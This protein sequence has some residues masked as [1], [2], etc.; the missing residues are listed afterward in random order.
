MYKN[1]KTC[2]KIDGKQSEEFEVKVEVHQS[3][4]LSPLLFAMVMDKIA[5]DV[6]EGCVKELVYADDMKL[7][8]NNRKKKLNMHNGKY[9]MTEKGLK[10]NVKKTNAFCTGKKTSM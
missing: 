6:R 3:T 8:G 10:V 1:I 7:L 2:I 5:K 4:S 9:L